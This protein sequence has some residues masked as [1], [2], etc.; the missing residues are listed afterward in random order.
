MQMKDKN[1][2]EVPGR[3]D[4]NMSMLRNGTAASLRDWVG[5]GLTVRLVGIFLS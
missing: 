2:R 1:V 3:G 4:E 5:N